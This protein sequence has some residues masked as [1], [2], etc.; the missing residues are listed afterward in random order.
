MEVTA[1]TVPKA[2]LTC[3]SWPL[4]SLEMRRRGGS[5]LAIPGH[6]LLARLSAGPVG[7]QSP[8]IPAVR[9]R[10][11]WWSLHVTDEEGG[12]GRAWEM[13]GNTS[14]TWDM[15]EQ[16]GPSSSTSATCKA[17]RS[18]G[19]KGDPGEPSPVFLCPDESRGDPA[20]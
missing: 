8:R 4:G 3:V 6:L 5:S 19:R 1:I 7:A 20:I 15:E 14:K 9:G 12:A 11:C 2:A 18:V 10:A 17:T 13:E 16:S